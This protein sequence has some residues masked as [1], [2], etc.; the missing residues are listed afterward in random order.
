MIVLHSITV[1]C[2]R[3]LTVG[4]SV[5]LFV[6]FFK[7][8]TVPLQCL[9][10]DSVTLIS[11]LLLTYLLTYLL[12]PNYVLWPNLV[13]IGRCEVAERSFGL[14]QKKLGLR[15]TRP[16]PH[17]VRNGSIPPKIPWTLSPLDMSTFTE[18]GQDRLR[19]AGLILERLLV[20][21]DQNWI[22]NLNR[23]R[24]QIVNQN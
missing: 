23:N 10:R 1:V 19:F 4:D 9:W 17:F 7:F 12:T 2:S 15:G 14:P 18:F 24:K 21:P 13:K 6:C 20:R 22:I 11:T 3:L 5:V 16:S 8:C